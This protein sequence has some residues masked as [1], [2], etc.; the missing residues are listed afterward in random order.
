MGGREG[1]NSSSKWSAGL[2]T[3]SYT[4][5]GSL[6]LYSIRRVWLEFFIVNYFGFCPL[7]ARSFS[8]ALSLSL[9]LPV[10]SLSFRLARVSSLLSS[11]VPHSL[12]LSF[13]H[14]TNHIARTLSS[15]FMLSNGNTNTLYTVA[16]TCGSRL[17]PSLSLSLS[18]SLSLS[19]NLSQTC[20]KI[21]FNC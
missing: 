15:L 14:L 4:H 8:L 13:C 17:S 6:C 16:Y 9:S 12:S 18:R 11:F 20:L 5:I 21:K 19:P 3:N 10:F 2:Q 1:E 7:L